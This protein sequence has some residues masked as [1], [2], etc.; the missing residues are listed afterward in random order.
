MQNTVTVKNLQS[1]L[2]MAI[3]TAGSHEAAF[4]L[5]L[6]NGLSITDSLEV[7]SN[8]NPVN[9]LSAEVFAHYTVNEIMPATGIIVSATIPELEGI[10]YWAVGLDFIIS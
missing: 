3:Q 5:A 1:V 2:D 4:D 9:V 6:A 7:G 10:G 8:L